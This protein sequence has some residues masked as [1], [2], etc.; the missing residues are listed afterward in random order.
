MTDAKSRRA[1]KLAYRLMYIRACIEASIKKEEKL[2]SVIKVTKNTAVRTHL[3]T[4]FFSSI[5]H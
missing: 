3:I 1:I 5:R 4:Y 2:L